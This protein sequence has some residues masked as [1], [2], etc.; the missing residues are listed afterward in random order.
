MNAE[1]QAKAGATG[2]AAKGP[3]DEKDDM[4][5]AAWELEG[6]G[7][8]P[9]A[10]RI[11]KAEAS[12]KYWPL[13]AEAKTLQEQHRRITWRALV[14]ATGA[15]VLAISQLL[16]KAMGWELPLKVMPYLEVGFAV[17]AVYYVGYGLYL[18]VQ[19]RWLLERHKAELL[20][21]LKY[22]AILRLAQEPAGTS[23]LKTWGQRV[24]REAEAICQI[25]E[26][27]L[28]RWWKKN[29]TT[30]AGA[31]PGAPQANA[32]DFEA[33][34]SYYKKKRLDA[35]LKY[36]FG[37]SETTLEE[38]EI[39]KYVPAAMF[40]ASVVCAILHVVLGGVGY[41]GEHV[42]EWKSMEWETKTGW[43]LVTL[44]ALFPVAGAAFRTHR[45]ANEFS[46]NTVRY[47]AVYQE[48]LEMSDF[49]D[50][51]PDPAQKI[52]KLRRCEETLE[53]EHREWLRLMDEAEWYG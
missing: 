52:E 18:S 40:L 11:L 32:Q 39:T 27:D 35:Q 7:L 25:D 48:L 3:V 45:S 34:V 28:R 16:V 21:F 19:K 17:G 24:K 1:E 49:L 10:L 14:T 31:R 37:K 26:V 42:F 53:D 47:H 9:Q 36:F 20:R 12:D 43:I 46:R 8:L 5:D 51:P 50:S 22:S 33:I 15:V 38:D 2:T 23:D 44:A 13:N 30:L 6:E 29:P 41:L 4:F